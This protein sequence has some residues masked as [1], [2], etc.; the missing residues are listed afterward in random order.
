MVK[1]AE[2]EIR[3]DVYRAMQDWYRDI[4]VLCATPPGAK[5]PPLHFPEFREQLERR[6]AA[7]PLRV[8]IRLPDFVQD[9][10][11]RIE[12]RNMN[13]YAF[14]FSHWLAWMP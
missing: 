2:K 1:N 5:A 13:A 6:A 11:Y 14:V 9:I 7:T 4:L 3:I 12:E 10:R 8:A